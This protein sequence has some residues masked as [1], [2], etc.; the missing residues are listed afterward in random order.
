MNKLQAPGDELSA[1][2]FHLQLGY[3]GRFTPFPQV[4]CDQLLAITMSFLL[5]VAYLSMAYVIT[6][7][8]MFVPLI[9]T[10]SGCSVLF[11]ISTVVVFMVEF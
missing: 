5:G 11:C 7:M 4:T 2:C 10:N 6:Y 8:Y 1:F 9:E 3:E